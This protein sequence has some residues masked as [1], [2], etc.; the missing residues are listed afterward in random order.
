MYMNHSSKSPV[1]KRIVN[2]FMGLHST[3][4]TGA[5]VE[6]DSMRGAFPSGARIR[7]IRQPS[8]TYCVNDVVVYWD[9][10]KRCLVHRIVFTSS[11]TGDTGY[12]VTQGDNRAFPDP[13]VRRDRIAGKVIQVFK[14]GVWQPVSPEQHGEHASHRQSFVSQILSVLAIRQPWLGTKIVQAL[15]RYEGVRIR[16][17]RIRAKRKWREI[18]SQR[19]LDNIQKLLRSHSEVSSE[20]DA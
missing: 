3:K 20:S 9:T 4:G 12:L 19:S 10:D 17:R 5:L 2:A 7:F 6:G 16:S 15:S 1:D 14:G 13:P 18:H 11:D 8:H